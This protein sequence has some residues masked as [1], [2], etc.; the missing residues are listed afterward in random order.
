[1]PSG[2]RGRGRFLV[3]ADW[4]PFLGDCWRSPN[5][6][7]DDVPR[8][9][10][11]VVLSVIVSIICSIDRT[12]MSVAIMP[13]SEVGRMAMQVDHAPCMLTMDGWSCH[14]WRHGAMHA[15]PERMSA[16]FTH[17]YSSTLGTA[18]PRE[19]SAG[20]RRAGAHNATPASKRACMHWQC[21]ACSACLHA[22]S[23]RRQPRISA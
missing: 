7:T 23:A 9:M 15:M 14:A 21:P 4:I 10:W 12:A 6:C 13:M 17:S 2:K 16:A 19:P 22:S 11:P 8:Y 18:V 5:P 1:M 3:L 20:A